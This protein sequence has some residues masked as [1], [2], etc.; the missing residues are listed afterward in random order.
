M[1]APDSSPPYGVRWT[2]FLWPA[3]VIS[4]VLLLFPQ[5][6]FIWN[7]F[8]KDVGAGRIDDAFTLA[9]YIS[10]LTD[11]FYL[12]SFWLTFY[13][14]LGAALI[15]LVFAFPTAYWLARMR[16]RWISHLIVLLLISLFV[17]I[18]I[19][20]MGITVIL[21]QQG[22]INGPLLWLGI[23][24]E[25]LHMLSNRVGV[26]IGLIQYTLPLLVMMLFSVIQTIPRSL[27]D[28]AEVHGA[29]RLSMFWRVLLPMAKL[30]VIAS[31]FIAFNLGM[32]AFT[33][34]ILLGGGR[35]LTLPILIQEKVML[36]IE[37]GFGATLSTALLLVVFLL[38]VVA[39][40]F[41]MR[42]SRSAARAAA[43]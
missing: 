13:L 14:A 30:G 41:L 34:A 42:G 21:S 23:I 28:A 27:E 6:L 3:V 25:P 8:H 5:G 2:L 35:V 15:G 22:M 39:A 4:A 37:Y 20:I 1:S 17:T 33:S 7:S 40:T 9:N 32:G 12:R 19:K 26:L 36:D 11:S 18:I 29:T 16:S 43:P 24:D 10:V 31:T 38:N